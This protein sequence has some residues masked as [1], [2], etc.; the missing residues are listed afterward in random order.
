MRTPARRIFRQLAG[1][2]VA[3][4]MA[5]SL[6]CAPA[7]SVHA[8]AAMQSFLHLEHFHDHVRIERMVFDGASE[9]DGGELR[10]SEGPGLGLRYAS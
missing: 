5:T 10:P 4:G 9:P 1:L 6:H 8:G 3:S 2:A 7:V